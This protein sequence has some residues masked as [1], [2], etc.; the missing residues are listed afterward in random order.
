[1][2]AHFLTLSRYAVRTSADAILFTC[3]AFGPCIEACIT[4]LAPM[5][6]LKPNKAMTEEAL[7][8]AG[9]HGRLG[10]VASFAPT[11]ASMP[12]EFAVAAPVMT[13]V[14]CL[15][16][17]AFAALDRGDGAEHGRLTAITAARLA[18]C[19]VL[20]LSQ[21]SLARAAVAA[22][23]GAASTGAASTGKPVLTKPDSAVRKPRRLLAA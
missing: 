4:A 9:P 10:L 18:D 1:M 17:G 16:E 5:P 3:S 11:L 22:S 6:V 7:V 2:T 23:T 19:D 12:P 14:P 20:A 21:F 8:L 13:L 15:V